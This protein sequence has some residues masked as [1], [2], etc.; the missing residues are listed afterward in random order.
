MARAVAAAGLTVLAGFAD[1]V[2]VAGRRRTDGIRIAIA[3]RVAAVGIPYAFCPSIFALV[4][5]TFSMCIEN[6]LSSI[7]YLN[8]F[9]GER[10]ISFSG[11]SNKSHCVLITFFYIR[12]SK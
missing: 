9:H 2:T 5:D 10:T 8:M 3:V 12:L 4:V 11:D 7:T 6:D 1:A